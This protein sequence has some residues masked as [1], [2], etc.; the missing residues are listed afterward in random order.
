MSAKLTI[1]TLNDIVS[2]GKGGAI[3]VRRC[4]R[5]LPAGGRDEKIFPSTYP[6]SKETKDVYLREHHVAPDGTRVPCVIVDSVG[7]QANRME[8]ALKE[9]FYH[10]K[11]K[12]ADIPVI[13]TDFSSCDFGDARVPDI[14][15]L[16]APHRMA[17]A[18]FRDS[19]LNGTEFRDSSVGEILNSA[20]PTNAV[21][22]Y[23]YCPSALIYGLWDSQGPRGGLGTK[24]QRVV[25]SEI[26]AIDVESGVESAIRKDPLPIIKSAGPLYQK[27]DGNGWTLDTEAALR[28]AGGKKKDGEFVK[29]GKGNPSD[30]LLGNVISDIS[31]RGFTMDHAVQNVTISIPALQRL[32]FSDEND[33]HA[34]EL[35][36]AARAALLALAL[37]GAQLSIDNGCDLRSRCLLIPDCEHPARWEVIGKD[38]TPSEIEIE[39]PEKLVKD[40]AAAAAKLGLPAWESSPIILQPSD[41]LIALVRKSLELSG[42]AEASEE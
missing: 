5:L 18:I 10:G 36:A 7:S 15:S 42:T 6:P 34:S 41:E 40:A 8:Q 20:S 14:T 22:L 23:K 29:Y 9:A 17:D 33:P 39:D 24:F 27:A 16:D 26:T 11:N 32:R 31:A 38:G 19:T 13:V 4:A 2:K 3:A 12:N 28:A 35:D 1:Q 30:A 25:V 37:A 21:E